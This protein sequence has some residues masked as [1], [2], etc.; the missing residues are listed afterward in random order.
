MGMT[1]K[2]LKQESEL[3]KIMQLT[4]VVFALPKLI[5]SFGWIVESIRKIQFVEV[6]QWWFNRNPPVQL[7][8]VFGSG[9]RHQELFI[10]QI[11]FLHHAFH[12]ILYA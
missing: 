10:K 3:C 8:V 2:A 5:N 9:V 12:S 6:K 7:R 4:V 11:T 1:G